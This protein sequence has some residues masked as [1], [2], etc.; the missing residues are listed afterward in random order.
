MRGRLLFWMYLFYCSKYYELFDTVIMVLKKRPL[1]FLHVYHHCVVMPLFW[2][3]M[4]TAMVI[5]WILVVS[6]TTF[7]KCFLSFSRSPILSF[8]CLCITI[9][10]FLPLVKLY[11]GKNILPK[12]KLS[13]LLLTLQLLGLFLFYTFLV[14][15]VLVPCAPGYLV[16]LLVLPFTNFLWTFIA[17]HIENKRRRRRSDEGSRI[18]ESISRPNL[19]VRLTVLFVNSMDFSLSFHIKLKR[20][21]FGTKFC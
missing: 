2:V 18:E 16:N 9:M 8:T 11:G 12:L 1:N 4:Q 21:L 6:K 5:H 17:T 7:C 10:R 13:S 14:V 19:R 20:K 3:Y 15:G